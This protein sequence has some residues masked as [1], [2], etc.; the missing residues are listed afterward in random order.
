MIDSMSVALSGML[1]HE[2]GLNVISNNVSNMNTTAFR[3]STVSFADVFIGTTP[4]G[5]ND[6]AAARQSLGGGL[7]ASRT[8]VD[9]R[10]GE[11]QPTGGEL[12]LSLNGD[13]FFVVQDENGEIR[14]TRDGTF[15]FNDAGEL[16][17]QGQNVKVM[18]RNAS[19]QLVPLTLANLRVSAAKPTTEV[20]FRG[21]LHPGDSEHTLDPLV[22]FDALGHKRTLRVVFT[23]D[24]TLP[25]TSLVQW[26]VKVFEGEQQVGT[27]IL[28][29]ASVSALGQ[30]LHIT[31]SLS[32]VEPAAIAFNFSFPDVTGNTLGSTTDPQS[33]L[34]INT[35]DGFDVGTVIARTFDEKGVL[36]LT[37][38]NGQK[39]DGP[40]LVLAQIS[41]RNGLV[42]LGNSRFAYRGTQAVALREAGDDLR[43][44]SGALERS[45][46]SLTQEFSDLILMQRGYQA[47][48]Q[49]LSTANDMLQALLDMRGRR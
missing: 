28:Q 9:F 12:D 5:R 34:S 43:V 6:L 38:S 8:R 21:N 46:V 10:P 1:G 41:D 24:T 3:G 27:D 45:N 16:V 2:R 22:I 25:G 36:K 32:G 30:P 15:D 47:S 42:E 18:T 20:K 23:R 29:F 17:L 37:Y 13:G 35:Q 14:Y 33:D 48:S 4:N 31:L 39:A 11:R 7:D 40:K 26:N 19:G 44:A 49:V